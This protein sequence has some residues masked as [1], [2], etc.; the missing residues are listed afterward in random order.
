MTESRRKAFVEDLNNLEDIL[1]KTADPITGSNI[2]ISSVLSLIDDM[3]KY[4]Y[5]MAKAQYDMMY[6]LYRKEGGK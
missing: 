6:Y 4:M 1:C 3:R 2:D 5:H